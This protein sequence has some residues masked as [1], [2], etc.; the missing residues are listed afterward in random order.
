MLG[1][2]ILI[3]GD[4]PITGFQ[5][6]EAGLIVGGETLYQ[7]A[8]REFMCALI[9]SGNQQWGERLTNDAGIMVEA[10]IN[11]LNDHKYDK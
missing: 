4:E 2:K 11:K 7:R 3:T 1:E 8:L 5:D 10:Y 9:I 6:T